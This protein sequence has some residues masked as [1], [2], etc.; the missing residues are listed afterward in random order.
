MESEIEGVGDW[1]KG[2]LRVCLYKGNGKT[3]RTWQ[4][5]WEKEGE[6]VERSWDKGQTVDEVLQ[7][8]S[9]WIMAVM[10]GFCKIVRLKFNS[11]FFLLQLSSICLP[12]FRHPEVTT[13]LDMRQL[14]SPQRH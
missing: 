3:G 5:G 14:K 11:A 9:H 7:I 12:S 8:V 2:K 1:K 13:K 10:L 4:Q 6:N